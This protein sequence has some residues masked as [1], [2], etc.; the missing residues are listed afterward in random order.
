MENIIKHFEEVNSRL[1]LNLPSRLRLFYN[2]IPINKERG[3]MIYG[4][5]GAGKTIFLLS[6]IKNRNFL[7]F[8]ADNPM[9][10]NVSL[11]DLV[12]KVFKSGYDG[13]VVDE[14]HFLKDWPLHIKSLYDD[15]PGKHIWIS[16]SSNIAVKKGIADLSRRF[17]Q[18]HL[19]LLSFREFIYLK[20]GV[21]LP[22]ISLFEESKFNSLY[23]QIKKSNLNIIKL[24]KEH[25]QSGIRPIFVESNYCEK[26]K[27]ALEKS[28]FYDVPFYMKELSEVYLKLMNSIISHLI[29]SPIPTINVSNMTS[30]WSIGKEKLYNI[31]EVMKNIELI[32]IIQYKNQKTTY[33]KGAKIFLSD[34]SIYSCFDGDK[35]NMRESYFCNILSVKQYEIY[36]SKNEEEYDYLVNNVK[37]EIGGKNKEKKKSDIV[38]SDDI[39]FPVKN[40]IPL[41][42]TGMEY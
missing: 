40:R 39:D 6:R 14:I 28:I 1:I 10:K 36:A 12:N 15:F 9:I 11:Y 4:L 29:Y 37:F 32:K 35:G 18:F 23:S 38:I 21:I 17:V 3:A 7:Y 16:G 19:P 22:V 24:F 27:S 26:L 5:R 8:S 13:V 20:T 33:T 34:S 2:S 30:N 42:L 31:L 25:I 41:W